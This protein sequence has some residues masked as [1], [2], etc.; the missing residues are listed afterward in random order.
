MND[1]RGQGYDGTGAMAGSEKGVAYVYYKDIP[2]Q[3]TFIV[4]LNL[5][6]MKCIKIGQVKSMFEYC[7][8]ISDFF[9]NSPKRF[10]LFENVLQNLRHKK[11]QKLIN[12]CKT[13]WVERINGISVFLNCYVVTC[14]CLKKISDNKP[15]NGSTW[16]GDISYGEIYLYYCFG[17]LQGDTFIHEVV[18][19]KSSRLF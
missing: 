15:F 10:Q 11:T 13:R 12:F 1:C 2:M 18:Y 4:I 19:N 3:L 16:N 7:C 17:Y 14:K 8:A 9:N 6:V 5:C